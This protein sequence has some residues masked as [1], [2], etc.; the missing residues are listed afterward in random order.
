MAVL[1]C[2]KVKICLCIIDVEQSLPRGEYKRFLKY[3]QAYQRYNDLNVGV[4]IRR[5]RISQLLSSKYYDLV[6]P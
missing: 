5:V 4:N 6:F 1:L 2:V 3:Y